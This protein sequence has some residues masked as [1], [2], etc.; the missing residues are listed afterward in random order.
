MVKRKEG[1]M[2]KE[3]KKKY[4]TSRDVRSDHVKANTNETI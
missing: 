1:D 4:H 3:C 2:K